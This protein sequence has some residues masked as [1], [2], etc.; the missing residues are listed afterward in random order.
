MMFTGPLDV[1]FEKQEL[2][3]FFV[4]F[5]FC[6]CVFFLFFFSGFISRWWI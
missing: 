6:V 3:C 5:D 4:L 1:D 2:S